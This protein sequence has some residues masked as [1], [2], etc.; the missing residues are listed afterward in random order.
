MLEVLLSCDGVYKM[1]EIVIKVLLCI[2]LL[3]LFSVNW[4]VSLF[5]SLLLLGGKLF[6]VQIGWR[7]LLGIVGSSL[8]ILLVG[9][10]LLHIV[11]L[12]ILVLG[13]SWRELSLVDQIG[14]LL[15]TVD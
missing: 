5:D 12:V 15:R 1:D 8:I 10:V 4:W 2:L 9:R 13:L 11:L 14:V 7:R 6:I 3:V